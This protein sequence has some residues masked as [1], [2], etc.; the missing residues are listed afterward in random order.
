MI[1]LF[2]VKN[3]VVVPTIHC[4]SIEVLQRIMSAYLTDDEYLKVYQ[5]LYYM[6]CPDPKNNPFFNHKEDEKEQFIYDKLG[7]AFSLEDDLIIEGLEVCTTLY[8]TPTKRAYLGIKSMLDRLADYMAKT[9]VTHGRDGNITALV[10]AAAK[11]DQI[12][13][14]YKGAYKDLEKE[15]ESLTVH[16]KQKLAYDQ[17]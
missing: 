3:N 6:T 10:N 1:Q 4:Y 8:T 5:F 7:C 11:F 9:P 15:Q 12:R 2:D 14:S 16:G 13:E 17:M